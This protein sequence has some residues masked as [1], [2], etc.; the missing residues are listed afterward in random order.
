MKIEALAGALSAGLLLGT[1][2]A[3]G[4]AMA[5]SVPAYVTA[6]VADP[7]RPWIDNMVDPDLKPA[8]ILTFIGLKPGDKVVNFSGGAYWDRLFSKVVGPNGTVVTFQAVEMAKALKQT[9]PTPGSKPYP[10]YPN[11]IAQ[12]ASINA[13]PPGAGNLDMVWMRQNYHDLYDP[14]MGR[15][16]VAAVDRTIFAGL[17]HGG[18]FVVID[19]SAPEGS[20]L[21][22]TNTTHRIDEA[23]VK[24]DLLAA[25]F[26]LVAESDLYR[27]MADSREFKSSQG[28]TD[29]F[30]L[31]F[32]K[33]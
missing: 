2:G 13:L 30:I 17:K 4:S 5:Q 18:V 29:R 25:G 20:G 22:S 12:S 23:V 7:A 10:D 1:T 9:L 16:D 24:K 33:P 8:A 15:A 28:D 21:A 11:V 31:L 27:N 3:A 32:R 14:F 26:E 19:H 6:A